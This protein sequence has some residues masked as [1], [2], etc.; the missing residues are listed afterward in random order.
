[1]L[2]RL[3]ACTQ[4]MANSGSKNSRFGLPLIFGW[5]GVKAADQGLLLP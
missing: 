1:M 5:E 4:L 2:S 3:P